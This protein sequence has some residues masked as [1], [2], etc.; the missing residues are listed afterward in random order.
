MISWLEHICNCRKFDAATDFWVWQVQP[1]GYSVTICC[2]HTMHKWVTAYSQFS[3]TKDDA[4]YISMSLTGQ[5]LMVQVFPLVIRKLIFF[6]QTCLLG[7]DRLMLQRIS[8]FW[9]YIDQSDLKYYR[10]SNN[11]IHTLCKGNYNFL[12]ETNGSVAHSNEV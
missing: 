5:A 9:W 2:G 1:S 7:H 4:K 12:V 11:P 8:W 3:S 6:L 10:N